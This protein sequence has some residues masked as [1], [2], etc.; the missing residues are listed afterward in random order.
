MP[1][2][3]SASRINITGHLDV[4]CGQIGERYAGSS[5]DHDASDYIERQFKRMGLTNVRSEPFEFPNWQYTQCTVRRAKGRRFQRVPSARPGVYS[6]STPRG[7]VAGPLAYLEDGSKW[8]FDQPLRGRIGLIVGSLLLSQDEVKQRLARS[9]LKAMLAVD[10]RLPVAW[11]TSNGASPAW[12]DDYRL[13]T[14]GIP[15][16]DA[17]SLVEAMP[18]RVKVEV[19]AQSFPATSYNVVAEVAGRNT[20][21]VIVVSAHHDS[22]SGNV[23]ADDNA[24]GVVAILELARLFAKRKPRRTLR[25]ISYGVE[26]RLSIGSYLYMRSL[27]AAERKRLVCCINFDTVGSPVGS[28]QAQIVGD[29][30]LARLV[31]KIWDH[32]RHP[33]KI[34]TGLNPYSDQFPM[35]ILGIP[36]VFLTRRSVA[37]TGYW[38]LHSVHDNLDHVS[39]ITLKRTVESSAKVLDSAAN[40]VKLPFRRRLSPG[41]MRDVRKMARSEYKHPWSPDDFDY[42]R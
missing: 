38:N 18:T 40:S 36:S 12:V 7:G 28:D 21:E 30:A 27:S 15:F 3:L 22:V 39:S 2:T 5:G 6:T 1:A 41:V 32:R 14:V 33:L 26:E 42:N 24:S 34:T 20:D 23:G 19:T 13:P 8:N 37:D 17:V 25:F 9:G 10:A 11:A 29:T 16:M 35:N 4:L 31:E